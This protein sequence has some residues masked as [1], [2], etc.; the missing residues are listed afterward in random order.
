MIQAIATRHGKSDIHEFG[1]L[2]EAISVMSGCE[3]NGECYILGYYDTV[4][5][6][7]HFPDNME[8]AGKDRQEIVN[9]KMEVMRRMCIYPPYIFYLKNI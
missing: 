6:N 5:K 9:E 2:E 1:K 4:T 7:I 8:I 3:E